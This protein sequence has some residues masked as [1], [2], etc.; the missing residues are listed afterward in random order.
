MKVSV[1]PVCGHGRT[2]LLREIGMRRKRFYLVC[3]RC[4]FAAGHARTP[5]GAVRLWNKAHA[6]K[7]RDSP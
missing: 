7:E 3:C 2:W 1:C 4:Q 5:W 6:S